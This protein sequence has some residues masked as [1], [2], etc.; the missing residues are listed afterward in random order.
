MKWSDYS[1]IDAM[2]CEDLSYI[3]FG[4]K[5]CLW[6]V[7]IGSD[8]YNYMR[9]WTG[10]CYLDELATYDG[11]SCE[12]Y[13]GIEYMDKETYSLPKIK[14]DDTFNKKDYPIVIGLE[15]DMEEIYRIFGGEKSKTKIIIIDTKKKVLTVNYELEE[16][17]LF[18]HF[19]IEDYPKYDNYCAFNVNRVVD[20]PIDDF[21][22]IEI[23][24]KDLP[25]W[26]KA[27]GDDIEILEA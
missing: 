7:E 11:H 26:I 2:L 1:E 3:S 17:H 24:E 8:L 25:M 15:K 13:Y 21:I 22:D 6:K 12:H 9:L 16:F 27:Y 5:V 20:I 4:K 23:D 19:N 14:V 10:I 18:K